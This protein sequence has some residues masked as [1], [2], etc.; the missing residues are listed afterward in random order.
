M[1]QTCVLC[2]GVM[3]KS[4]KTSPC[5]F[6]VTLSD[7]YE[8]V[9]GMCGACVRTCWRDESKLEDLDR[10]GKDQLYNDFWYIAKDDLWRILQ[11]RLVF[12]NDARIV[13]EL[14]FV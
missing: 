5:Q 10:C 3:C 4:V 8:E 13:Q 14:K 1:A 11:K 2:S 12:L 7:G 6:V 9:L